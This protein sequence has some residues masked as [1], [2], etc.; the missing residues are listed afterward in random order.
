[1]QKRDTLI[2][3]IVPIYNVEPFLDNCVETIL[4][5][6]YRNLEII[7]V[8]DGSPD[9]CPDKCDSWAGRDARIKVIHQENGGLSAARNA[10]L[11]ETHGEYVLFVDPDD[12]LEL[13]MIE[14]MLNTAVDQQADIVNCQFVR[15]KSRQSTA[16]LLSLYAPFVKNG[17]EGAVLLCEDETVTSHVWR[18]LFRREL[19]PPD[20]FPAGFVFEDLHVM[21]EIFFKSTKI[22][23][24]GDILYHYFVNEFGIVK[25]QTEK[26]KGDYFLA[27]KKREEFVRENIPEFFQKFRRKHSRMIYSNWRDACKDYARTPSPA[28]SSIIRMTES[29]LVDIPLREIIFKKRFRVALLKLKHRLFRRMR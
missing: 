21:H 5:Q 2:S 28:L 14:T 29:M 18:N 11:R 13:H 3:V 17:R 23:F 22:V 9:A 12:W 20:L 19:L 27:L 26:N 24:I 4:A 7:L 16:P 15:E 1:M 6:T 10:G 8:D 25:T